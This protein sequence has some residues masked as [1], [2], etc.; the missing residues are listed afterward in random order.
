MCHCSDDIYQIYTRVFTWI[1]SIWMIMKNLQIC[2]QGKF[3]K[4]LFWPLLGTRSRKN[5]LDRV[6][7][8]YDSVSDRYL[9][10]LVTAMLI[11]VEVLLISLMVVGGGSLTSEHLSA[12]LSRYPVPDCEISDMGHHD[13]EMLSALRLLWGEST[14]HRCIPPQTA[15]DV[16]H[17]VSLNIL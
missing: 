17:D 8:H 4:S 12:K 1:R 3:I 2:E 10:A 14:G 7:V 11:A 15:I 16:F 6:Q 5:F 13:V 9:V